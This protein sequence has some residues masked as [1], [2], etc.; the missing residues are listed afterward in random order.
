MAKTVTSYLGFKATAEIAD[1]TDNFRRYLKKCTKGISNISSM[2]IT[3]M[4]GLEIVP[5]AKDN[6]IEFI[7]GDGGEREERDKFDTK[8]EISSCYPDIANRSTKSL[9]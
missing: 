5:T 7:E 6:Y 4:Q 3:N 1:M 8:Q 9:S 2:Y